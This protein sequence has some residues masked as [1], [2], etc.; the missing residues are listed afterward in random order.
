MYLEQNKQ[1]FKKYKTS[2]NLSIFIKKKNYTVKDSFLIYKLDPEKCRCQCKTTDG[3]LCDHLICLYKNHFNVPDDLIPFMHKICNHIHNPNLY[4][5]L[6]TEVFSDMCI[7]CFLPLVTSNRLSIAALEECSKCGKYLH[8]SCHN[9][10]KIKN[11]G[12]M[13]CRQ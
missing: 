6:Q 3:V 10:W 8:K 4:E 12:C 13:F 9:A 1:I 2:N 5:T 7:V 11:K